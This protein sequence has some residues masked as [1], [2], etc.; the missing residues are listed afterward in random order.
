[1]KNCEFQ[2]CFPSYSNG[3]FYRHGA[4][5]DCALTEYLRASQL[6]NEFDFNTGSFDFTDDSVVF[7]TYASNNHWG[8]SK[9]LLVNLRQHFKNKIVFYDLG[10]SNASVRC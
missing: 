4:P 7:V 6:S 5:F 9:A 10:L 2:V 1:M 8:E 3:T